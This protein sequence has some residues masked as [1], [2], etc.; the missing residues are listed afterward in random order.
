MYTVS[1]RDLGG[2]CDH[3]VSG[4]TIDETKQAMLKHA[5]EDHA[6]RIATLSNDQKNGM[7]MKLTNILSAQS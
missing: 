6:D 7:E 5:Q 4:K 1:C 2:D 3:A